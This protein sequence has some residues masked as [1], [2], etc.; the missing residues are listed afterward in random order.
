MPLLATSCMAIWGDGHGLMS[1]VMK[2][3]E[4][5]EDGELLV[6]VRDEALRG[7]VEKR[8]GRPWRGCVG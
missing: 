3:I 6:V 8:G 4:V 2:Y 7:T 5:Q 1:A